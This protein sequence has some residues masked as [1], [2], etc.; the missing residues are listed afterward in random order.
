MN[1]KE[2]L[3]EVV[4]AGFGSD[5]DVPEVRLKLE[6]TGL[7]ALFEG[8]EGAQDFSLGVPDIFPSFFQEA[9]G[10]ELLELGPQFFMREG[11]LFF[12]RHVSSPSL[13]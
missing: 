9:A 8:V 6:K 7:A 11:L 13:V 1:K 5:V 10:F 3:F 12:V 2:A 4:H